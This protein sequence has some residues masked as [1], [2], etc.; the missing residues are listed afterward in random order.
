MMYISWKWINLIFNQFSF[1]QAVNGGL[2]MVAFYP[3]FVS[4]GES[5]TLKDV[6]GMYFFFILLF[7]ILF[8]SSG[9]QNQ[10]Q[11]H[12]WLQAAQISTQAWSFAWELMQ[13]NKVFIF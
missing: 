6:V 3:H 4:C 9:S 11:A 8:Y 5:A 12:E 2:V 13:P 10:Q 7:M 1:L